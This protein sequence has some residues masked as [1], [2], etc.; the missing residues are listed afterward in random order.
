M[1]SNYFILKI[2]Y[3]LD[4]AKAMDQRDVAIERPSPCYTT[5]I[6]VIGSKAP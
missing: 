2:F 4:R 5:A 1:H 3:V 6:C